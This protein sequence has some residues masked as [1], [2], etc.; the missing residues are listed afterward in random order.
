MVAAG[1]VT[2]AAVVAVAVAAA[3]IAADKVVAVEVAEVT[4]GASMLKL[5]NCFS[6]FSTNCVTKPASF[7]L[8]RP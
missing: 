8:P 6:F 1:V 7:F 3:I 2:T 4:A 5:E